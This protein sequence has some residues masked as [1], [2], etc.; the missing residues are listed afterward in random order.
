MMIFWA[1]NLRKE[2]KTNEAYRT[3][4]NWR[5]YTG[6]RRVTDC[7]ETPQSM[8]LIKR[9]HQTVVDTPPRLMFHV[10]IMKLRH[11]FNTIMK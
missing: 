7:Q 1:T 5:G 4:R 9:E 10:V 2:A 8:T 6:V 3:D 11:Q